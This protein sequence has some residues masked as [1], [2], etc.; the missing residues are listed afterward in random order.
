MYVS[1]FFLEIVVVS[2][3]GLSCCTPVLLLVLLIRDIKSKS[4]W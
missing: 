1:E 2:A 4:L 3:L